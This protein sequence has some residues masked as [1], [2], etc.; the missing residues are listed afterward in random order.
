M[1]NR[2]LLILLCVISFACKKDDSDISIVGYWE[3]TSLAP[4]KPFESNELYD[5]DFLAWWNSFIECFDLSL[6]FLEN[7]S[8]H[9]VFN[10]REDIDEP[11]ITESS[12]GTWEINST[13]TKLYMKSSSSNFFGLL[14][15]QD[16]ELSKKSLILV[17]AFKF[18]DEG[19]LINSIDIKMRRK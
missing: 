7:G 8:V 12:A 9:I 17:G 5:A 11:C 10:S 3:L 15:T 16:I 19:E 2:L 4:Q 1:K 18:F 14:G 6:D 13:N